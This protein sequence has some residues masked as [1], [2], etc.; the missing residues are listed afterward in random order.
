[1][2][3]PLRPLQDDKT[4]QQLLTSSAKSESSSNS[5]LPL[6]ILTYIY[7]QL[8]N[9]DIM[10]VR[11]T[12]R[13]L[14]RTARLRFDRLFLS[15]NS[16]NIEVFVAVATHDVFRRH[17]IE[18]LWDDARLEDN[19]HDRAATVAATPAWF[20]RG[21]EHSIEALEHRG[22][23]QVGPEFCARKEILSSRLSDN[24][25]WAYY[26][27]LLGQQRTV[28]SEGLDV[29]ALQAY[30]LSGQYLPQLRRITITSLAHG[31]LFNPLY[32]TPMI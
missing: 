5:S 11:L 30:G 8:P 10:N 14:Q 21:C 32:E 25:S 4:T 9:K 17:I 6:E 2:G 24:D 27:G 22:R 20:L 7:G 23:G 3:W 19:H 16:R 26:R 12:C 13:F 28:L 29:E 1:M 18:I 15:A 31:F